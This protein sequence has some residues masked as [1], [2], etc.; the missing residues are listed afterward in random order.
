[1]SRIC[2]ESVMTSVCKKVQLFENC[3]ANKH[4]VAQYECLIGCLAAKDFK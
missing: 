1:M 4:F 3:L 2:D